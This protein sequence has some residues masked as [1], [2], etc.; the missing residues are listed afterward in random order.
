MSRTPLPAPFSSSSARLPTV[1]VALLAGVAVIAIACS[2]SDGTA[3]PA[4]DYTGSCSILA[5][6]CHGIAND[7]AK[8]CHDLGHGG[9]I[10]KC[11][12]KKDECLA[13]CPEGASEPSDAG[14]SDASDAP[15]DATPD[16]A[17]VT[18]CTC[19]K[20]TCSSMT[21]YP[22]TDESTCYSACAV[23]SAEA[24]TCFQAFC[25]EA[26]DSG[27]KDHACEHATGKLGVQ[28]CP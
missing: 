28:E 4:P 12:P 2:S 1:G 21:N 20:A 27:A 23:Y 13:V 6:R 25:V 5:S 14:A 24:R 8:E 9:D 17:C 7:L 10:A 19:M 18:Y 15:L 16:P 26:T 3:A 11:G 22:F